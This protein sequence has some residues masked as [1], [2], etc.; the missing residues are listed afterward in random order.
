MLRGKFSEDHPIVRGIS[1]PPRTRSNRTIR[2][3]RATVV[4]RAGQGFV[5]GS[6][7]RVK[8]IVTVTRTGTGTPFR[9]VGV[10]CHCRTASSAA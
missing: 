4:V 3:G 2:V 1:D 6:Y 9:R 7:Y 10:Y 8:L 5:P